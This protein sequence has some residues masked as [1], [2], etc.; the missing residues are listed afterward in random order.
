ME[1]NQ[2]SNKYYRNLNELNSQSLTNS[3]KEFLKDKIKS[4]L[5]ERPT[6]TSNEINEILKEINIKENL[7]LKSHNKNSDK[8]D[9]TCNTGSTTAKSTIIKD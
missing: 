9:S 7:D 4:N 8:S 1:H 6:F 2:F 5:L 3:L